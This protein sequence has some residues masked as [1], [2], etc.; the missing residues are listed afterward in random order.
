MRRAIIKLTDVTKGAESMSPDE[1]FQLRRR[2]GYSQEKLASVLGVARQQIS[3]WE[4]GV[5]NPDP[6]REAVME[7]IRRQLDEHDQERYAKML[8]SAVGGA[9]AGVLLKWLFSR[10]GDGN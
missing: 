5:R 4:R 3:R 7:E 8:L 9:S 2:L 1:I 10:G 6:Y